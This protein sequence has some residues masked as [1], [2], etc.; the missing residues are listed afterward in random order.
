MYT[1]IVV[2]LSAVWNTE[3]CSEESVHD[4]W[5]PQ[6]W[7]FFFFFMLMLHIVNSC[8]LCTCISESES[9]HAD[10]REGRLTSSSDDRKFGSDREERNP[11][12]NGQW[13][14]CK[15]ACTHTHTHAHTCTHTL[16]LILS[17]YVMFTCML[18]FWISADFERD[19]RSVRWKFGE[20]EW[21][22]HI[23]WLTV[24]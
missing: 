20:C 16:T 6:N 14:A 17:L 7:Y 5:L 11:P 12:S 21:D 10:V 9:L 22:L 19:G 15:H 1:V 24:S 13:Q 23:S 2:T 18:I 3:L 4:M 8:T